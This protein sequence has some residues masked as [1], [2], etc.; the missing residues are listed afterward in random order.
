[1]TGADN[2]NREL[3]AYYVNEARRPAEGLRVAELELARRRDV[4]TLGAHAW[5]LHAV[6]RT[7]EARKQMEAALSV[8]IKDARLLY[9]AGVIAARAGDRTAA[10]R[11]LDESLSANPKSEVAA[12]ARR[13]RKRLG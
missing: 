1:M 5:A 2:C 9:Q 7:A 3:S 4:F 8:G 12:A 10:E 13:E 6:G 11:Y